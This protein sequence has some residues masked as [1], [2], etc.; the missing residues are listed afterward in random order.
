[1][2]GST[3]E[4]TRSF[5]TRRAI[6]EHP[7]LVGL[8]VLAQDRG[9]QRARLLDRVGELAAIQH[10]QQRVPVPSPRVDQLLAGI[11]IVPVDDRLDRAG[12][13]VP[14]AQHRRPAV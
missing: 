4:I 12:V 13:V 5:A 7:V 3:V 10:G 9:Q 1:V 14:T 8:Q 11:H 2:S 6:G